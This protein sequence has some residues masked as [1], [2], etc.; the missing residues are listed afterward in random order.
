MKGP[1]T[2]TEERR[3]GLTIIKS[4]DLN[5]A[6]RTRERPPGK[7]CPLPGRGNSKHEARGWEIRKTKEQ[8]PGDE[9]SKS[10]G[11]GRWNCGSESWA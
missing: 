6:W 11:G 1:E 4:V 10:L 2:V 3:Q 7:P 5:E 8:H 9:N